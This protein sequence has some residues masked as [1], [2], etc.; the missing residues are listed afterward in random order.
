MCLR[1]FRSYDNH[2]NYIHVNSQYI[3]HMLTFRYSS[4]NGFLCSLGV[5]L[6]LDRVW[7]LVK[8]IGFENCYGWEFE[9]RFWVWE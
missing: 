9:Y 8:N 7:I 6:G 2:Y 4:S 1:K 3:C 5:G